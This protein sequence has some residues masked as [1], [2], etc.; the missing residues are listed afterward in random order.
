MDTS[1]W[2]RSEIGRFPGSQDPLRN[3]NIDISIIIPVKDE[4]ENIEALASEITGVMEQQAWAWEC[5]WVDDGS[6][7]HSRLLLKKLAAV[8]RHH[9]YL[10]F[11]R[12]AG[13][14]AAFWAGFTHARGAILVTM[15]GDGQNDPA[16]IPCL[17]VM[18]R[19]GQ[20]DMAHG[21]RRKRED[22]VVRKFASRIANGFRNWITGKTVRDVGCSTRALRRECVE[23]LP[24]FAGMHRFLPNLIRLHGFRLAEVPVN[25]RPRLK[26]RS[27]YTI[28]NRLWVG[29]V[30]TFG[31]LWFSRRAFQY[32]IAEQS[33][34]SNTAVP[35]DRPSA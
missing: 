20:T 29:L 19:S 7:D 17:V 12:N 31:V 2:P 21:Y 3:M 26:G 9:R 22:N 25:H 34:V 10:A 32:R 6:T 16:D 35:L 11:E 5:I 33:D 27:K 23:W 1:R 4:A 18:V 8:D 30:D 28:S 24:P 15:D 13:Q 14:S